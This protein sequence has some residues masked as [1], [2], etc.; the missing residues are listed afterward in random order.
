[1]VLYQAVTDCRY[2][3]QRGM[4]CYGI[5]PFPLTIFHTNAIHH[6][7]ERIRLDWFHEGIAYVSDVVWEW[8]ARE[9]DNIRQLPTHK[10][11]THGVRRSLNH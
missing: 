5:S 10:I 11:V 6:A 1:M 2:L 4:T 9:R 7:N 8:A 3:R